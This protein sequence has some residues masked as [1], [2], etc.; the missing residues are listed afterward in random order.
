MIF[1]IVMTIRLR[2]TLAAS[3]RVV[4]AKEALLGICVFYMKKGLL[5]FVYLTFVFIDK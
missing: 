3:F 1:I 2:S 5:K 4:L